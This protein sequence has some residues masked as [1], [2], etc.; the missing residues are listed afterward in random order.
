MCSPE[1]Q[2]STLLDDPLWQRTQI[3]TQ[4][5]IIASGSPASTE[6]KYVAYLVVPP[7]CELA[8][9]ITEVK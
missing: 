4:Q 7:E 9:D 8:L 3:S 2:I 1:N 5:S 6:Y